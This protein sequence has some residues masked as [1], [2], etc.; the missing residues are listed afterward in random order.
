[1]KNRIGSITVV[2]L[3]LFFTKIMAQEGHVKTI[4]NGNLRSSGGYGALTNK[5]TSIRGDHTNLA[6]L[7]G[8]WFVNHRMMVGIA[9]AASTNNLRV[10][11][12]YSTNTNQNRTWQYGQFGLITEFIMNSDKPLHLAF[13]L[14]G[15]AGFTLQYQRDDW[16]HDGRENTS[17]ENWFVVA[18]PGI[19]LEINLFRWMRFSP[20][21]SYRATFG[22]DGR[23]LADSDLRAISYN[24]TVKFGR[25]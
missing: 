11:E 21:I 1:M 15:G 20:G 8:G 16:D 22:S 9:A 18:E 12:Q 14:F 3:S 24:A 23:G 5:F 17:D 4:F 2:L 13:S 7:Y 19:Q 25:F 6:G 10:P